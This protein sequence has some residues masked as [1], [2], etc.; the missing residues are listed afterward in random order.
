MAIPRKPV[1]PI[2]APVVNLINFG[3][4]EF[5]S[6]G[7]LRLP[8]G[9]YAVEFMV[10][11]NS[12]LKQDGTPAGTPKLGVMGYFTPLEGG[13]Q[14]QQFFSMGTKAHLSFAPDPNTGKGLV[15]VAGGPA[16]GAPRSTGWQLFLN[17]LYDCGLPEGIF[18]N[19]L[20]AIDGVWVH[21]ANQPEPAERK[22]FGAAKTGEA[23]VEERKGD[24]L[25]TVAVEIIEGGKPWEGTGGIPTEAV[26][27]PVAAPKTVVGRIAPKVAP[28]PVAPAP[29]A[30]APAGD[31]DDVMAA[32]EAAIAEILTA[33]PAGC[34]KLAL[35]TGVFGV[36]TKAYG[37]E[38]AQAV[39]A[40][41]MMSDAVLANL[42]GTLGYI[43]NGA[44]I[45]PA[46]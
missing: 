7:G 15:L 14:R 44:T 41:V 43:I 3:A 11:M 39:Q 40:Q 25:M 18:T 42:L 30:A 12:F 5:Y 46:S 1:A 10:E 2:A 13:E 16:S 6:G 21:T 4:L 24:G 20:T 22:G 27:A 45:Q 35:K 31:S 23:E 9:R 38:M 34:P 17:S 26:A 33:K 37:N 29:V 36:I 19:D 8:E 32:A 28:K